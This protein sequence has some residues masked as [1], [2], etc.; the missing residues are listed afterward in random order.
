MWKP[1]LLMDYQS[2]G[3]L[4]RKRR[5]A[6]HFTRQGLADA[7]GISMSFLGHIERGTRKAN[8][9]T[10]MMIATT[11]HTTLNDMLAELLT[12]GSTPEKQALGSAPH[13]R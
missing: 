5:T 7:A 13:A 12:E 3:Y 4:I 6:L 9:Q 11:L 8:L 10:L 1:K 2:L